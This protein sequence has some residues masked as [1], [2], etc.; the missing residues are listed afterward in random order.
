M[1]LMPALAPA[2]P[3]DEAVLPPRFHVAESVKPRFLDLLTYSH[4]FRAQC[5]RRVNLRSHW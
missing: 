1:W 3:A 4:T 2:A 5:Q